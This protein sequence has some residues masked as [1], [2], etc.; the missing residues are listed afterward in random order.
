MPEMMCAGTFAQLP[1][2]VRE[3]GRDCEALVPR[4]L[5]N[6][7][8]HKERR[9]TESG[10]KPCC[11]FLEAPHVSALTRSLRAPLSIAQGTL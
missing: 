11:M 7:A 10:T 5:A 3:V 1:V 9:C 4:G 6:D 2:Q 8:H